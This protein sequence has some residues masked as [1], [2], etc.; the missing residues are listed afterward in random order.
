MEF[1]THVLIL[2]VLLKTDIYGSM[3]LENRMK[4]YEGKENDFSREIM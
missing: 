4:F 1:F 2:I 3:C